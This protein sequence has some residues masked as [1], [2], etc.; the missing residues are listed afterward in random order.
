M[1]AG[2]AA[3]LG[4]WQAC[5]AAAE[6]RLA[7]VFGDH[8]V[9]Q[10]EA[11]IHVWGQAAPGEAVR[12]ILAGRQR[13]AVAARDGRWSVQLPAMPAGGPHELTL[14]ASNTVVLNDVQIGELWVCAGQSNMEWALRDALNGPQEA[15]SADHPLIRYLK[16]PHRTA[17][18]ALPDMAPARWQTAQPSTA[19]AFSAVAYFFARRLQQDQQV[20][21][22]LVDVS[23][24][25][26]HLETWTRREAALA[27]PDLSGIVHAMPADD[28]SFA[29]GQ[30][31]RDAA[32]VRRWQA[33]WRPIDDAALRA[34]DPD[35][36][37]STWKT[38]QVPRVWEEQGLAG[39][40]GVVWFRK[41]LELTVEQAAGGA[42][43]FLGAIDDCDESY[44]NGQ[45][46]GGQC[47]WD[48]PRRYLVPPGVLR[49]GRNVVAVRVLDTGGAGGFHGA[50]EAV[51]L[52]SAT[53][54]V[55]LAGPWRARV[56]SAL[57][58][59]EP[60]VND[61][62]TLAFNGMLPPVL[63]L[64]VR[65]VLWY[66]GESN[67]PRAARYGRA[68]RHLIDDWRGQWRQPAMPFYFVQL[69]AFLPLI[70]NSLAGS[71][72]AELRDAQRQALVLP[73]TGMAVTTDVGD[74][75]DI[76]PRDKQAV[77][78]RLARLA[79]H[80]VHGRR[81]VDSGPQ[82]RRARRAGARM[83]LLFDDHGAGLRAR[84]DGDLRGFA[85]ADAQRRFVP[86]HARI[87]G[88]RIIVWS[89]RIT[90]PVAVRYGWV[91]NPAQSNLVNNEGL[92]AS[93][94]RTD[95]WP[96]LTRGTRFA[97]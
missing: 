25:G 13:T 72:W 39:F 7:G 27:D 6:A 32:R 69:A 97:P 74:E 62:P 20:P 86:A 85:V 48:A 90:R 42:T 9:L 12:V 34:D 84:D 73:G 49:A 59:V 55:P 18:R 77:G 88:R 83:V 36:D 24:G 89:D 37:D 94:F 1:L 4:A 23:W 43:L 65:G 82:W 79:L 61:L 29:A 92:P 52:E 80:R 50:A 16:V 56:L 70:D 76:H 53:S 57:P 11:P 60:G 78:E 33:D 26:T 19:G 14:R 8:M 95:D 71:G 17:L 5:P 54:R 21:V 35:H 63:P 87:D 46:V 3:L 44:V 93:P 51:R 68:F 45:R 96:L 10:R 81:I 40:D 2:L 31:E 58:K 75:H 15:A 22:G 28:A 41:A 67:V 38:L 47:A 91:D 30:A 64:R 66:Q